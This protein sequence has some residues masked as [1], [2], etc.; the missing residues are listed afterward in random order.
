MPNS[1]TLLNGHKQPASLQFTMSDDALVTFGQPVG[2]DGLSFHDI[3][4]MPVNAM[5]IAGNIPGLTAALTSGALNGLFIQYASDGV[6]HFA[7]G[8]PTTIDYTSLHYQLLGYTG[9]ATFG[10]AADGTP[11][12]S[13]MLQ[14][15]V[16]AQGDLI[17]GKLAFN[18]SGGVSGEL[19]VSMRVAGLRVGSVDISVQHSAADIGHTATGGLTLS[20]GTAVGTFVPLLAS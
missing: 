9:H 2:S 4:Y 12:V 7:N 11:T 17:S 8:L 6:Q 20:N 18:T 19:D 5:T 10:H 16:L 15:V 14:E 1:P 13:G 3:G